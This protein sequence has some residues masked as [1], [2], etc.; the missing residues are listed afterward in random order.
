MARDRALSYHEVPGGVP[1]AAGR[2]GE[3]G[4]RV[5]NGLLVHEVGHARAEVGGVHVNA[6]LRRLC[7][8]G[9]EQRLERGE[10]GRWP[11][12][13]FN[14]EAVARG[15]RRVPLEAL[16]D[17]LLL[18]LVLLLVQA[19]VR[20]GLVVLVDLLV[21]D[22]VHRPL[23][24]AAPLRRRLPLGVG[25]DRRVHEGLL[26]LLVLAR[27]LEGVPFRAP[28]ERVHHG[29]QGGVVL[30]EAKGDALRQVGVRG[31][32]FSSASPPGG[33][34]G[35]F[36]GRQ[37]LH[38]LADLVRQSRAAPR[39]LVG[40]D[41]LEGLGQGL[42]GLERRA[43]KVARHRLPDERLEVLGLLV[44]LAFAQPQHHGGRHLDNL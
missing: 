21:H 4:E 13:P 44:A 8:K 1:H 17:R 14:D 31:G 30:L 20:V 5:A 41:S 10:D 36:A 3:L 28:A 6:H 9:Q 38:A 35:L 2:G 26:H 16:E 19:G 32:D 34:L 39:L 33:P 25:L 27:R 37:P 11:P 18:G 23:G 15:V 22:G 7:D 12:A 24:D 42:L 40:V 29:D 43:Q